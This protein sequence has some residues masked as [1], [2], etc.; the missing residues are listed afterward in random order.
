ML[1]PE[2]RI[3]IMGGVLADDC[4]AQT[5]PD[6]SRV[7]HRPGAVFVRA[8]FLRMSIHAVLCVDDC[9]DTYH[10][11]RSFHHAHGLDPERAGSWLHT[12]IRG[13]PAV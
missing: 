11:G 8:S 7:E 9:Q 10:A 5:V 6:E 1:G 12:V 13:V 2:S 4:R 3:P